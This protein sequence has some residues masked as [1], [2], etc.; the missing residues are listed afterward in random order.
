M[1]RSLLARA[2]LAGSAAF[3]VATNAFATS[4]TEFPDN[5]S[6][7]MARGGAWVARA[8][9]P[10]ATFYNPAGLAGQETRVTAQ[11]NLS[12]AH[13]CF[14]RIKA[15]NDTTAKSSLNDGADASGNYPK[16]CAED[17]P[18]PN[19]QL[20]FTWRLND[21]LSLGFL[22]LMAPSAVGSSKWPEFYGD[23]PSPQR[24][25]LIDSNVVLITPSIGA[26]Y[27][28]ADGLRIGASFQWGIAAKIHF[29]N[30]SAALN[31]DNANPADNDVRAQVDAK[32]IFIP[33][34]TLGALYSPMDE[35]DI[36]AWYR[37]SAPIDAK[38]DLT[39]YANYFTPQVVKGNVGNVYVSD[40][41]QS[42]CGSGNPK[43]TVCGA[44]KANIKVNIPMEAKLGARY[45]KPRAAG[46][47][48]SHLRDP[49]SQDMFDVELD[50]TWANNSALDNVQVRFPDAGG[51]IGAIPI[52]GTPNGVVPPNADVPHQY[53]DVF[54]V[55]FGGDYNVVADKLALRAGAFFE[56]RAQD[57]QY[58]NIDFM[59]AQRVG[60]SLGGTYRLRLGEGDKKSA[61]E[62][63]LGYGHVFVGNQENTNPD[64]QGVA[65]LT[66]G[67]C[68]PSALPANGVCP[69]GAQPYRTNWPVNLG[70]ISNQIN[71]INVGVSYRF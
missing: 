2:A 4:V 45:H 15:S 65:A 21:R 33:G 36:A 54:G 30:A 3:F 13:R 70:T 53:K 64:A 1:R 43:I 19:P 57:P 23:K 55:R 20:G 51:G 44:D 24:Y 56:T 9:D 71:V 41:S 8:S 60:V 40:T 32:Q 7:Q 61:L 6:E 49:L 27:E 35:L 69:G 22:P 28:V 5:G 46:A 47:R 37:W 26:G 50:L 25:M 67:P 14:A 31:S 12:L 48:K 18:F 52:N 39:T 68:N 58:Q 17:T 11:M 38:G 42:D 59:G 10:L 66:G 62:F 34:F 16:V 63:M 29:S